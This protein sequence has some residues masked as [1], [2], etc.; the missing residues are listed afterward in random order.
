MC[1]M[2]YNMA[3]YCGQLPPLPR[4]S[5]PRCSKSECKN[6]ASCNGMCGKHYQAWRRTLPPRVCRLEGCDVVFAVTRTDREYCCKRHAIADAQRRGYTC[7]QY[8]E[9]ATECAREECTN[10]FIRYT[11]TQRYCSR[12]CGQEVYYATNSDYLR[13][14]AREW[15]HANPERVRDNRLRYQFGIT[16][17]EWDR[18]FEEQG[19]RC[20][21]CGGT[22]PITK[23]WHVDHCH[24]SGVVRGI[25]CGLCN[26]GLGY[27]KDD[28]NR[29][30]AAIAYLEKFTSRVAQLLPREERADAPDIR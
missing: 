29:L 7:Q 26:P 5:R 6:V 27:F 15:H 2:H 13:A 28:T 14:A 3:Y 9:A 23:N 21:V 10:T 17:A 4:D 24:E 30:W 25:L 18:L 8:A 1:R 19:R 22:E 11:S 16:G 12:G 20:A